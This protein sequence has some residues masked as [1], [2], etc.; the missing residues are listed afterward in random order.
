MMTVC[1][2]GFFGNIDDL[3]NEAEGSNNTSTSYFNGGDGSQSSPYQIKTA[4]QLAKLAELVNAGD[5]NYNAAYYILTD[6]IN[7]AVAP[8]N[9]NEGWTP[10]GSHQNTFKGYFNGNKRKISGLFINYTEPY[11]Y[12]MG[13]FGYVTAG[14]IENLAVENVNIKSD[15]AIGAIAGVISGDNTV[16]VNNCYTTGIIA[17]KFDVGG[18][19]GIVE[20]TLISNCYSL[21][22]IWGTEERI[23]GIA[24]SSNKSSSIVNCYTTGAIAGNQATGGIAGFIGSD[25]KE[26]PS[27]SGLI[28]GIENCAA[29]NKSLA[30]TTT[31]FHRIIG[32]NYFDRCTL[33]NN[34]AWIGMAISNPEYNERKGDGNYKLDGMDINTSIINADASLGGRFTAVDGWTLENGK[35]PGLFGRAVD[36]PS[37]LSQGSQFNGGSGKSSDPYQINTA[38]QLAKLAQFVNAGDTDYN[39]SYYQL[40]DDINLNM[41]PYNQDKGWA[42]IGNDPNTFKGFFDGNNRK[43]TGLFINDK[44]SNRDNRGLFGFVTAGKIENLGVENLNITSNECVGG[45]AGM[46][47]GDTTVTINNCYTTGKITGNINT[48]GIVGVMENAVVSNCYSLCDVSGTDERTGGIAGRIS[49]GTSS[50]HILNCYAA[51]SIDGLYMNGGIAGFL[52]CYMDRSPDDS[53]SVP[54]IENCAALSKSM[55]GSGLWHQRIVA[56]NFHDDCTLFNNIAWDKMIMNNPIYVERK[57]DGNANWDGDDISAETI[58]EDGTLG[59]RFTSTG[60]WTTQN[61]KLPGLFGKAVDMPA[62]LS[63]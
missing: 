29:F 60:G 9:G 11:Q 61:G 30:G 45:I 33:N 27:G 16:I 55:S 5:T 32:D 1:S 48:G 54:S 4:T 43:I 24:G 49:M 14:K 28:A 44:P 40:T 62:Y 36:M 42:P 15:D 3:Q 51:G 39:E 50:S 22:D 41:A 20:N 59:G 56:Y 19:A 46:I 12:N 18:I 13:L 17:G 6:D 21:C 25:I 26:A 2:K 34:I 38:T 37:H 10:I 47:S 63:Q 35:L 7:L 23:G 8:Y 58:V 52:Y 57:G 53:G 31:S